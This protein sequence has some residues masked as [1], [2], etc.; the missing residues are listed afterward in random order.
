LKNVPHAG[1]GA[2]SRSAIQAELVAAAD[3]LRL[4]A[5]TLEQLRHRYGVLAGVG[6]TDLMALGALAAYGPMSSAELSRR[7]AITPSSVTALVDRLESAE[8]V[9][10]HDDPTDR[11]RRHL[12]LTAAGEKAIRKARS[13]SLDA[14]S[15]IEP[16][17]LPAIVEALDDLANALE[18]HHTQTGAQ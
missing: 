8:L 4:L 17:H 7:L 10:R 1:R 6:D 2:C 3:G 12:R 14:L 11:R 5:L 16:D 18:K 13:W 15:A 9:A